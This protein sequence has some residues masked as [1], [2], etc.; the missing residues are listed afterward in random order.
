MGG[1]GAHKRPHYEIDEY[2][3][4][5][6]FAKKYV[7]R[8]RDT[9]T[10]AQRSHMAG[11]E[12]ATRRLA[13]YGSK[14]KTPPTPAKDVKSQGLPDK[15]AKLVLGFDGRN[16]GGGR[17]RPRKG[18]GRKAGRRSGK[19]KR[20][21]KKKIRAKKRLSTSILTNGVYRS[22]YFSADAT[23]STTNTLY[24]GHSNV[25]QSDVC[26]VFCYSLVKMVFQRAGFEIKDL[27]DPPRGI[28]VNDFVTIYYKTN[29]ESAVTSQNFA[30]SATADAVTVYGAA[31]SAFLLTL[32][33]TTV[34]DSITFT[35]A[36]ANATFA[37]TRI[38]LRLATISL[39]L[40]SEMFLS[41]RT[42]ETATNIETTD[43]DA[44][45]LIGKKYEGKGTGT[46]Y[47]NDRAITVPFM[48][49][50]GTGVITVAPVTGTAGHNG[51]LHPA[52][53]KL[54]ARCKSSAFKVRPGGDW[55]S[56]LSGRYTVKIDDMM[57]LFFVN[58]A[59]NYPNI[60][61]GNY[62]FFGLE[63]QLIRGVEPVRVAYTTRSTIGAKINLKRAKMS[64]VN[65]I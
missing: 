30:C 18:N 35:P 59:V 41:N 53:G 16:G 43:L 37:S 36:A 7:K 5:I 17:R 13:A 65:N 31:L 44:Q 9:P 27:A 20:I 34:L 2:K 47:L 26:T 15:V 48:A 14:H 56:L 32:A 49:N 58:T 12:R 28:E 60:K 1:A 51:L 23:A 63:K 33:E 21:P 3:P 57:P 42:Y 25:S 10:A 50:F 19:R 46:S 22:E 62:R 8:L 40:K 64:V 52:D 11:L 29:N 24:V 61:F 54:F 45:Q 39:D 38:N 6:N 4:I 55:K